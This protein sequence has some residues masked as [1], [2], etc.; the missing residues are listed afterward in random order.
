MKIFKI[1]VVTIMACLALS[2]V[3]LADVSSLDDSTILLYAFA[4]MSA[5]YRIVGI[6]ED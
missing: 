2:A 1:F 3:R 6:V 5:L 4:V